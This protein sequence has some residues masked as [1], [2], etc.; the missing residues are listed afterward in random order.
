MSK[1]LKIILG[2]I[3][4]FAVM[5]GVYLLIAKK[6]TTP[7]ATSKT[8]QS[9]AQVK[10]LN[11][12]LSSQSSVVAPKVTAKKKKPAT[13]VAT[14]KTTTTATTTQAR[15]T[16]IRSQWNQCKAK[17]MPLTTNLFWNVQISQAIPAGGTY[18]KGNLDNDIAF[19]VRVIVKTDSQITARIKSM[20]VV[21]KSAFL[22]GNCTDF[23]TDGSVVLQVF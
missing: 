17:T 21:G 6:K 19:P 12:A 20:L 8:V 18:A 1:R 22:R 10:P 7:V 13:T 15:K 4:F 3:I 2:I 23:A 5:G 11:Q 16:L 14:S 9:S